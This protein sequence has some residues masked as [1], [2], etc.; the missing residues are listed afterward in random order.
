MKKSEKLVKK[1]T[2][3]R[4]NFWEEFSDESQS[5]FDFSEGYKAFLDISKTER[6][7]TRFYEKILKEHGFALMDIEAGGQ[8]FYRTARDKNVAFAVKGKAPVSAGINLIV[9]HIDAPRIDFKQSPLAQ[10]S[11]TGLGI[12]K[13]HYY[14]GVKKYQWM[15]TPLAIHGVIIK[16]DGTKINISI[17]EADEDPVFVMPD[18]LPHLARNIQYNEKLG[19]AVKADNMNMIFNSIPY[20][21]EADKDVKNAVKLNALNILNQKYDIIE[22]DLL[23]AEIE[24]VPAGK[25]RDAGIDK[26]MV[27]AYGQ[28]DRICAYTS[29]SA[30][31]DIA[32]G[33]FEK[34]AVVFLADKEEIGSEGNSG[35]RSAFIIDFIADLLAACGE[36]NDSVTLRKTLLNSQVLSADVNAAINPNFPSVHEMQNAV[37]L[38]YG[39]G[40]AKF[41]GSGG[42]GGSNDA[43]AEFNAHIF[44]I[45]N[46]EK[47]CWQSGELGK[48]DEGGGGTIAKFM[49]EYGA[50]VIDCGPGVLGMH[51]L[52]ELTSKADIYSSY[53][54]YK[55][56]FLKG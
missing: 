38:G 30:L 33:E 32:D 23:S 13:T 35:A 6:E 54:A 49:A 2:Y 19:A 10:D 1:L 40:I 34:T 41:T 5:A 20:F 9:S 4:K 55:T 24:I 44:R 51:S 12:I 29:A 48:V 7:A 27:L 50:E 25:A 45:F 21:E 22:E 52:Y 37:H 46:S 31:L 3:N 11:E 53:K 47:V 14:G 17:G 36:K 43:N 56:F 8:K 18:L 39:V 15:S 16:Q 26:S 42:K 28:D